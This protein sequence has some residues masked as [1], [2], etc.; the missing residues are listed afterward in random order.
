MAN[1]FLLK[2]E[3]Q[4]QTDLLKAKVAMGRVPNHHGKYFFRLSAL[5]VKFPDNHQMEMKLHIEPT[6]ETSS[7]KSA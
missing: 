3:Y 1:L 5:A 2:K 6:I 4:E 7:N